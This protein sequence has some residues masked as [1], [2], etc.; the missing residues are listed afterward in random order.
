MPHNYQMEKPDMNPNH[1]DSILPRIE[2][3]SVWVPSLSSG[4]YSC[5]SQQSTMR[6]LL[7]SWDLPGILLFLPAPICH[8]SGSPHWSLEFALSQTF[9]ANAICIEPNLPC[10][11][12]P[13]LLPN[14]PSSP[15][16]QRHVVLSKDIHDQNR[17]VENVP[18]PKDKDLPWREH[19]MSR[20]TVLKIQG[21]RK[22]ET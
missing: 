18:V 19:W 11:A 12:F 2:G 17:A 22:R 3:V 20:E 7:W 14:D 6:L 15:W 16:M 13:H 9:P 1:P 10:H 5:Q 21:K 8:F 4:Q